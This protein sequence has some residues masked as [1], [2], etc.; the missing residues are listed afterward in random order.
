[1]TRLVAV[2]LPA[3]SRNNLICWFVSAEG[4]DQGYRHFQLYADPDLAF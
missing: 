4:S 3:R 1:M 2:L